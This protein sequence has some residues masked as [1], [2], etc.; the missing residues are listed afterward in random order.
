VID[1]TQSI[2]Q[3]QKQMREIVIEQLGESLKS[4]A[5]HAPAGEMNGQT[6]APSVL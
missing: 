3:Q 6:G 5:L 4:G 1:A 2:E